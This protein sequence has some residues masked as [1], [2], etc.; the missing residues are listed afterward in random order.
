MKTNF[1]VKCIKMP[2]ESD[3][4]RDIS[5]GKVYEVKW[6]DGDDFKLAHDDKGNERYYRPE[7]FQIVDFETEPSYKKRQMKTDSRNE[8]ED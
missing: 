1:K 7:C 4:V 3:I 6:A 2:I 5:I 8:R